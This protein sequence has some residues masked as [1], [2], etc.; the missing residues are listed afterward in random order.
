MSRSHIEQKLIDTKLLDHCT[1]EGSEFIV[2]VSYTPDFIDYRNNIAYEVKGYLDAMSKQ[3]VLAMHNAC[4]ND[5]KEWTYVVLVECPRTDVERWKLWK[6]DSVIYKVRS[7]KVSGKNA[8]L[9]LG[10]KGIQYI[11]YN[12]RELSHLEEHINGLPH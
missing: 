2:K 4:K 9:W 7:G 10:S 5:Y 6:H 3:K 8:C 11:P 1:Y 12:V